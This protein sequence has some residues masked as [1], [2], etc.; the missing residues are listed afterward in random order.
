MIGEPPEMAAFLGRAIHRA[1][2]FEANEDIARMREQE[3]TEGR[4]AMSYEVVLPGENPVEYLA[5]TLLPRLVY[6]LDSSGAKL[7]RCPGVFISLFVKE[8]LFF[9]RAAD[10]VE[11][12][13]KITGLTPAQMTERYGARS[14]P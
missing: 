4:P 8:D 11:E 13:A 5:D 3:G 6:F 10:A 7:P 2:A 12:L 1:K 14:G 9:I